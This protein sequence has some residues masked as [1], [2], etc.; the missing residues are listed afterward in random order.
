[1]ER[2]LAPRRRQLLPSATGRIL[3]LGPGTGANLAHLPPE[4]DWTGLEPNPFMIQGL[5]SR[6]PGRSI[7]EGKAESIPFSDHSFDSVI[8]TLVLC[9]VVDLGQ[10]LTEIRRVLRP[11]GKFLFLEHVIAPRNTVV[12]AMQ[13]VVYW[14]WRCIGEGCRTNRDTLRAIRH[15]FGKVEAET[16]WVPWRAAPPWVGYQ[17]FGTAE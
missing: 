6:F 15:H 11:G 17:V 3:E 7:L 1:M 5:Q 8:A 10:S 14:P 12:R 4:A 2:V 13:H 9:S 16:Y